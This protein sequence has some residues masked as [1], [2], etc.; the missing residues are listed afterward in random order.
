MNCPYSSREWHFNG[1]VSHM[2]CQIPLVCCSLGK[3]IPIKR[4]ADFLYPIV[5]MG[6]YADMSLLTN[7]G[8]DPAI[9]F[10]YDI[11]KCPGLGLN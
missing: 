1:S 2:K 5:S 7:F 8:D 4:L 6:D 11:E 3:Q 10:K 9:P